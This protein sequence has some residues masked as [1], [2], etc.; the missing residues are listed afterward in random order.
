MARGRELWS[1]VVVEMAKSA[2][3]DSPLRVAGVAEYLSILSNDTHPD[4]ICRTLDP[5]RNF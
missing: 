4:L 2:R 5:E 3:V 1:G